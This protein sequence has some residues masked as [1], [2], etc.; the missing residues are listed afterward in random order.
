MISVNQDENTIIESVIS[1][2]IEAYKDIVYAYAPLIYSVCYRILGN[3]EDAKDSTQDVFM[4]ALKSIRAFKGESRIST[5][6]YT[7]AAHHAM[8][9]KKRR[10][11]VKFLSLDKKTETEDGSMERE[12]FDGKSTIEDT[13]HRNDIEK[14]VQRH[15]IGLPMS[16]R[17]VVI[18]RFIE[19][20]SYEEIAQICDCPVNTVGSRLFRGL[21]ILRKN[22][23]KEF[24]DTHGL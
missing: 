5:W 14:I 20:K 9:K 2:N 23:K 6:L 10:S 21:Q 7:I 3:E 18:L 13:L 24:G 19:H 1:G 8:N 17:V 12:I 15:L 4:Y 16:L 11:I 22:M